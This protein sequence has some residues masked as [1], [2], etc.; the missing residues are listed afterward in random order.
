MNVNRFLGSAALSL[1]L[2]PWAEAQVF[3]GLISQRGTE[4]IRLKADTTVFYYSSSGTLGDFDRIES[5]PIVEV[6]E[7][8]GRYTAS[9]FSTATP[10]STLAKDYGYA[11]ARFTYTNGGPTTPDS[12]RIQLDVH[13]SAEDA[14]VG[15]PPKPASLSI[16]V[17]MSYVL[18]GEPDGG[19]F[20]ITLPA[21]P[22][23]ADPIHETLA[24]ELNG[25]MSPLHLPAGSAARVVEL[26]AAQNY[27]YTI[28]YRLEVPFG[29]DPDFSYDFDGGALA[30][31]PV[32]EPGAGS[33]AVGA[34]CA[35]W[36]WFRR[37]HA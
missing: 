32:P 15:T 35:L 18:L 28:S 25:P 8:G 33:F 16:H 1:A 20:R 13:G 7:V 3:T 6:G 2:L 27:V 19:R 9:V 17:A 23:V 26:D 31:T 4:A 5:P 11:R 29:T 22:N 21:L 37:R 34:G 14:F 24:A 36:A 10:T 12:L 30:V